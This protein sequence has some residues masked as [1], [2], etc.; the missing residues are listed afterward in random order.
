MAVGKSVGDEIREERRK[1]MS[2]MST[3]E[4]FAYFWDYYKIHALVTVLIAAAAI[5]LIYHY[6]TYKDY[7]FYALLLNAGVSDVSE[8][9]PETWAAEF[10]EYADINPK[11]YDVF[12]DTSMDISSTDIS[13]YT[14]AN[15]QKLLALIQTGSISTIVAET[16]TF[17]KYAQTECFSPL[18]DVLSA[19]EIEKYRP[20]FYY[21]DAA[22]IEEAD[23]APLGEIKDLS[24]LTIDHSDPSTM[25]KPVAVG[26]IIT[27]DNALADARLYAY[28]EDSTYDY[29]GYPAEVVLGIPVTNT[30]PELVVRFLEYLNV[31][32]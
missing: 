30:Q 29:Q 16:E 21:T 12:V 1:A 7:G 25:E 9:L 2:R 5:S 15:Q 19:E 31:G 22:S 10:Q 27:R 8:G 28:L 24:V 14:I 23:A 3:K 6:V 20:Y 32:E 4:K 13:Q 11:E 17:E 26:I 18:E